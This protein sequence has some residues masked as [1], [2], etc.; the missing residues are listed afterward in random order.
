MSCEQDAHLFEIF[1]YVGRLLERTKQV[2]SPV[3]ASVQRNRSQRARRKTPVAA[4]VA[5]LRSMTLCNIHYATQTA[6]E[7]SSLKQG[8]YGSEYGTQQATHYCVRLARDPRIKTCPY[9]VRSG[10]LLGKGKLII[11]KCPALV[12]GKTTVKDSTTQTVT[13]TES[14]LKD[15]APVRCYPTEFKRPQVCNVR[16]QQCSH[17]R[18]SI[19][20]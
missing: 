13:R 14:V 17:Y 4:A 9:T 5:E 7:R 6:R 12:P 15:R 10:G 20:G 8:S 16:Y 3:M 18:V 1:F 11:S 2:P 19:T